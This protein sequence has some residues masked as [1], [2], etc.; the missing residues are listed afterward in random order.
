[1]IIFSHVFPLALSTQL[2]RLLQ[3][4]ILAYTLQL[5]LTQ[6]LFR[7]F[8]MPLAKIAVV[9]AA[10]I[11]SLKTSDRCS[12]PCWIGFIAAL[13]R[14]T[15]LGAS[16]RCM[17]FPPFTSTCDGAKCGPHLVIVLVITPRLVSTLRS[18]PADVLPRTH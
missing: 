3:V 4:A 5:L 16:F 12:T 2:A 15:H 14:C 9:F 13:H 7:R 10:L 17:R 8:R 6:Y 1:M 11:E 18:I